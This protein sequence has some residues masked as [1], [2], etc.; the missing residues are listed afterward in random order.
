MRIAS[1]WVGIVGMLVLA[2][3]GSPRVDTGPP[4]TEFAG[5]RT[6]DWV[7]VTTAD[8]YANP[9]DT[10]ARL[11]LRIRRAVEKS[12]GAKGYRLTTSGTPDFLVDYDVSLT[13]KTTDSF[14]D[15]LEYRALGGTRDMGETFMRGFREGTLTLGAYDARSR[16][17][18]WR[19]SAT[20]TAERRDEARLDEAVSRMVEPLPRAA[21]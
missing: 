14:K 21:S 15:Y 1:P 9:A 6:Y 20:A 2:G 19:A 16:R 18:V 12:L 10:G 11:D 3:C 17:L 5:Y 4:T 7:S 13:Q 8:T